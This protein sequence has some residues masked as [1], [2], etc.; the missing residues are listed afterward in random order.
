MDCVNT[1]SQ[2]SSVVVD[3]IQTVSSKEDCD[4]SELPP[5]NDSIDSDALGRLATA[6]TTI[7]FTY[8]GH[9][10]TIENS[11]VTVAT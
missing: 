5:L 2:E 6:D 11:E 10:I 8:C 9:E 1:C 3:I 7:H 4:P